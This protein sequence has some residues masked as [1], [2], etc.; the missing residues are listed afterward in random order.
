MADYRVLVSDPI[1]EQGL[2][3]LLE[4]PE[5]EVDIRTDLT[6][7][8]L[9]DVIADYDALLVRSQTRVTAD[10]IR[11]GIN[12]RAIGRAG[13][14]VDNIDVAAATRRGII[15]INA[16]DGNTTSTCEH[17]F[18]ML[19]SMARKIPQAHSKLKNGTWDRKSFVGVEVSGKTLGILGFG[20]IGSEVARRA[21]AFNMRVLAF[22]PFLT[23]ERAEKL[24]VAMA[25]VEEIVEQSD[26]ITVHTP[27]TKETKHLLSFEQ[28]ARMKDGVRILNC[29]R[30]GIIDEAALLHAL[31]SGK[32]AGAALDVFE[33]EPATLFNPLLHHENVIV[34]PHLGASTK[35]AQINVAIDVGRELLHILRGEPFKNAVNLPSLSDEALRT[36]SPYVTLAEKAGRLAASLT[37]GSIQK[38]EAMYAGKLADKQTDP[39]TR[40]LLKGLLGYHHGEEV[41]YVNAPLLAEQHR[42]LVTETKT[43]R[44]DLYADLLQVTVHTEAHTVSVAGTL[45]AGLGPRIVQINDFQ[46]DLAPEGTLIMTE[47]LDQPGMIGKVGTLLGLADI[48][49]ASMQVG[50]RQAGGLAL[51]VLAVDKT[52]EP[53]TL[54]AIESIGGIHRVKEVAL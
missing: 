8:A 7:D 3:A 41:N 42:I 27:L 6:P 25:T 43:S 29:A 53:D 11:A 15:V 24:G 32:V 10:V 47:H 49:I 45:I 35:E 51:M 40:S 14:G 39:L 36:I 4:A 33:E 22:D 34:T 26:F 46:V 1:S 37:E 20:R 30:G 13:V 54:A 19:L 50:R 21:L 28:F 16:P 9:L 12:L 31:N 52:L 17:T 18:A 44:H 2:T 48:N 5:V 38:I 23:R